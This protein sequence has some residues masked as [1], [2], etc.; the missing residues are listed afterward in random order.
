[1]AKK[2]VGTIDLEW[3]CPN[4]H[5]RNPGPEKT[6]LSCGAA[7]P[8]DVEFILPERQEISTDQ[9][10]LEAAKKGPDIHCPYC[11]ARNPQGAEICSQCGGDLKQGVKRTSGQV[12]GAFSNAPKKEILCPACG[13]P[14]KVDQLK[15]AN[16]G[17]PLKPAE[18]T[19]APKPQAAPV[20]ANPFFIGCGV[21]LLLAMI[22]GMFL[23][24]GRREDLTGRVTGAAWERAILVEEFGPV[25]RQDWQD[26]VPVEASNLRCE[27][28]F[29]TS[30]N[31]Y[32]PGAEEVCGTAYI[33]DSGTGQ[34]EVVQDC[35]YNIYD[36][37]CSYEIN[38]WHSG[39]PVELSGRDYNPIWP[40]PQ[41]S[42][43]QRL[44]DRSASYTIFFEADGEQYAF[45]TSDES[46]FQ[47]CQ[48]GTRWVLT[49][50]PSLGSIISNHPA[51]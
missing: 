2:T 9:Q 25:T 46:L 42:A 14:N 27:A 24:F 8:V 32:V 38:E 11:G 47:A 36:D 7:Q 26:E 22:I 4:C 41:L 37:Y 31:E 3:I 18:Q 43:D 28:R 19:S 39:S 12:I 48:P 44:G 17:A 34:G 51:D 50:N 45:Q 33:V 16:C 30:T 21:F 23:I 20:K 40:N 10:K 15:C 1:M 6:C 35:V 29:R 13:Q 5:N 49:V